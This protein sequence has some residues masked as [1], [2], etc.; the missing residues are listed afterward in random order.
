MN[1]NRFCRNGDERWTCEPVLFWQEYNVSVHSIETRN[2]IIG[3]ETE[4]GRTGGREEGR[5]GG[6]KKKQRDR[7]IEM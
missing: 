6:R 3:T 5:K 4:R 2:D 7:W 1:E